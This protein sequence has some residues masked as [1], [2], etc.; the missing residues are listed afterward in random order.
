MSDDPK[1][2]LNYLKD[3]YPYLLDIRDLCRNNNK[4]CESSLETFPQKALI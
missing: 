1:G 3:E 2:M 4:V